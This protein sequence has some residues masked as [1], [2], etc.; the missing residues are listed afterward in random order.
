MGDLTNVSAVVIT[1]LVVPLQG[2][3]QSIA[4]AVQQLFKCVENNID[5]HAGR[6][7]IAIAPVAGRLIASTAVL[8]TVP[9][10]N[11]GAIAK[12]ATLATNSVAVRGLT[13]S[14]PNQCFFFKN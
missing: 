9:L 11:R 1:L 2:V 3:A 7:V 13:T 10:N 6:P 4:T 5:K 14:E 8:L 12:E